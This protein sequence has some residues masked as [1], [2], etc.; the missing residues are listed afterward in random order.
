MIKNYFRT[1]WRNLIKRKT[2]S[3][4]NIFGLAISIA[5]CM[6]ISGYLYTQLSYD[7]YPKQQE[8]IYRVELHNSDNGATDV[9][10]NVDVAVGQGIKNAFP[11][12]HATT[13]LA[14]M[15]IIF[16]QYNDK[17]FKEDKIASVDSNF[18]ELFSIPFIE[19]DPQTALIQ[20]NS[21][22]VTKAFAQKYFGDENPLGK[23]LKFTGNI[24]GL[25][26]ISGVID[27]IPDNSHFHFDA[28]LSTTSNPYAAGTTWSNVGWFTYLLL[29][30]N[31]DVAKLESK[32]PQ[33][34][35]EHVVPEVQRDM[36]ISL[37]QAQKSVNTFVFKLQ[38]LS[39]IHLY[40]HTKYELEPGGDIQY[41]YIFGALAFF[42]LLLA[43]VN[44]TNLA[45]ASSTGRSKEVGIRKVL[46]SSKKKL[47]FQFLAESVVIAFCAL[48]V[49][50]LLI[51]VLLPLF[52]KVSGESIHFKFFLNAVSILSMFAFTFL[53]GVLAGIYPAFFLSSF[54]TIR[55]LKGGSGAQLKGKGFLRNGLVVFQFSVSM[56]LIIA[57]IV[58]YKQLH[59]MQ[60]KKLGYDKEQVAVINDTYL[61]GRNQS[62]F[63]EQLLRD[64]RIADVS[65]ARGV[66][67]DLKNMGG[68]QIYGLEKKDNENHSEIHTNIFYVDYDYVPAMGMK[69][70]AGRNLSMDFPSDSSAVLINESAA[71][72]LGWNSSNAVGKRIV[73]SGQKIFN[74]VGVIK[75]F[76]YASAKQEI[77]PLTMMLGNNGSTMIVKMKSTDIKSLISDIKKVWSSFSPAGPFDYSF[78][79]ES[80]NN[81]YKAEERTG[82]IFTVFAVIAIL[83]ASLGLFGLVA[84][85][86]ERRTK[87]IGVRKVLGSSVKG[88]I[89]LLTK[90]FVKLIFISTLVAVPVGWWSM[91]KWLEDFAYRVNIS[92]WIF[93]LA[94]L[95]ALLIALITVSFQAV[96]AAIANPVKS[97]RSE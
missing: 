75:D 40:S 96:K 49:S 77:A 91:N 57:T 10:P 30:K 61:L 81:L 47:V 78:L 25:V 67:A 64:S 26:K 92:W 85:T 3:F 73:R 23:S 15:P 74:V 53:T 24:D 44:F 5:C 34:V 94:G 84:Y 79:D 45:T 56:V 66:P 33:L 37:D 6:L 72:A 13:R 65:I 55:V 29:N 58:V 46:G 69:I 19:G 86:A 22:V 31:T 36:G 32:L 2:F 93:L 59:F 39:R 35:A 18:L 70:A 82:Q 12:V 52:N 7:N 4:I 1:A 43:C 83:I 28:F 11:E 71:K 95:A 21:L 89:F 48:G 63:K 42:I 9:Y 60:N 16:A 87:E 80:F 51:Y 20:P 14:P 76:Q 88:I 17:Q 62:A 8:Q 97:L 38:P 50:L 27:K 68:T 90:D 41:V 54:Q